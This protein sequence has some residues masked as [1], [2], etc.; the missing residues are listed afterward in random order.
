MSAVN[1]LTVVLTVVILGLVAAVVAM[2]RDR[3]RAYRVAWHEQRRA[4]GL[5]GQY[6]ALRAEHEELL[7][8]PVALWPASVETAARDRHP[9]GKGLRMHGISVV[10]TDTSWE[11]EQQV[12]WIADGGTP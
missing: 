10:P 5:A 4:D 1:G 12:V 11:P 7:T 3:M 2:D 9:V 8:T 6:A